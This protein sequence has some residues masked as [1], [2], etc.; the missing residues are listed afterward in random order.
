MAGNPRQQ[1]IN[2]FHLQLANGRVPPSWGPEKEREYSFRFYE[3][4]VQLWQLATEVPAAQH[5]PAIAL[6]LTGSARDVIRELDPQVLVNG[7][8]IIDDQGNPIILTGVQALLRIL[9]RRFAPLDQEAQIHALQEFFSF[10]RH[11]HEDTDQLVARFEIAWHRAQQIGQAGLNETSLAWMLLHHAHI[12]KDRWPLILAPTN[13]QL[14]SNQQEYILFLAYLRRNGHLFDKHTDP[15]KNMSSYMVYNSSESDPSGAF[16]FP[17]YD[18]ASTASGDFSNEYDTDSSCC[19]YDTDSEVDLADLAHMPYSEAAEHV[20][21]N[22]RFAKRRWR[23]FANP[24]RNPKGKGRGRGMFRRKQ[25]GQQRPTA[26][27]SDEDLAT[28]WTFWQGKSKGKGK[29]K[30]PPGTSYFGRK[31]PLDKSGKRM[32]C[33]ICGSDEHFW[34]RCDKNTSGGHGKTFVSLENAWPPVQ[35][36]TTTSP[37]PAFPPQDASSTSSTSQVTA[38]SNPS[39]ASSVQSRRRVYFGMDYDRII[40]GVEPAINQS[41][42]YF[43]DG[44]VAVLEP[45]VLP[46]V[47][48][49]SLTNAFPWWPV[50]E[51]PEVAGDAMDLCL[52]TRV[53]LQD[54]REGLVVDT[55]A[56]NSLT[57]D[58]FA[59]RLIKSAQA[60]GVGG[61]LTE[62]PSPYSIEGVG[63]GS[64]SVSKLLK[65][66]I[67]LGDGSQ[68]EYR[69]SVVPQSELPGLLGLGPMVNQRV[70]LDLIHMKY[71]QIGEGGFDMKLSPGSS[72][73]D[74]EIADSG[75]ILLPVTEWKK[76]KPGKQG[77]IFHTNTPGIRHSSPERQHSMKRRMP[78]PT[79]YDH[80]KDDHDYEDDP[81]VDAVSHQLDL[82]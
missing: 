8:Q 4:D 16:A 53:R 70:L 73:L 62:H 37:S 58:Q 45:K 23:K 21:L 18:S 68:A 52:H 59:N 19:S 74:M 82:D 17:A 77:G 10:R 5:G 34:K 31:N 24:R 42:I 2:A 15:A 76:I 64:Q 1:E 67:A 55:G 43:S 75:H 71:I 48:G 35:Q 3:A 39:G 11:G 22:Y 72:V 66:G 40:T 81:A 30:H 29:G 7:Q 47:M 32:L 33:S 49:S 46:P 12:P 20:Y 36:S 51:K 27:Y 63:K 13:G 80:E 61:A 25:Y 79:L 78:E 57:G 38:V 28:Q 69:A 56:I 44:E 9:R 26:F 60:H 54:G 41:R 65:C 50:P 6:R 14:P